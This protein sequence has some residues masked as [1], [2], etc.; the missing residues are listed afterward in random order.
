MF[1]Q[2]GTKSRLGELSFGVCANLLDDLELVI[3]LW[4]IE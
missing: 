3:S 1:R 2:Y 4:E